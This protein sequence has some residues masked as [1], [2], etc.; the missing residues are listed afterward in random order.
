MCYKTFLEDNYGVY[1]ESVFQGNLLVPLN[2]LAAD[3]EEKPTTAP[4]PVSK[5]DNCLVEIPR[6]HCN[7]NGYNL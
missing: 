1:L 5:Y 6:L 3:V 7:K 4:S 2:A